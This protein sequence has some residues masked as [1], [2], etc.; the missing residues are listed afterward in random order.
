MNRIDLVKALKLLS[1]NGV[2][3]AIHQKKQILH[4]TLDGGDSADFVIK[5]RDRMIMY[6]TDDVV[7]ILEALMATIA[8]SLSRGD[9]VFIREFGTFTLVKR[10]AKRIGDP[11]NGGLM[12]IGPKITPKFKCGQSLKMAAKLYEVGDGAEELKA[13]NDSFLVDEEDDDG[14][15]DV[16]GES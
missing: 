10:R 9:P 15:G 8:E 6:T 12:D 13:Y 2:K 14:D 3:K 4:I 11:N 16:N 7:N 1:D 5:P